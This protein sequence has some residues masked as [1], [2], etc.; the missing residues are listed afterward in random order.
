MNKSA[1]FFLVALGTVVALAGTDL[2]LPAI[3]SLPEHLGGD[4]QPSQWVLAAFAAGTG[5]GLLV[6]GEAGTH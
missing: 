1:T 3:P 6:Y 2:V 4:L 5:V